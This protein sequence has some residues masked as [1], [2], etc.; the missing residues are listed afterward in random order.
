MVTSEYLRWQGLAPVFP[1]MLHK[2]QYGDSPDVIGPT[3]VLLLFLRNPLQP[4]TGLLCHQSQLRLSRPDVTGRVSTPEA[5][6]VNEQSH[7]VRTQD[8]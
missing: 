5:A 2:L 4:R 8:S 3:S 6:T 7:S 1:C